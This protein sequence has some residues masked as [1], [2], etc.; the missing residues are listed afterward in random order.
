MDYTPQTPQKKRK[1]VTI[2]I[3]A[4][5]AALLTLA[6]MIAGIFALVFSLL[7][8][9]KES[10]EYKLAYEYLVSS[11]AFEELGAEPD[12]IRFNS[13]SGKNINGDRTVELGFRVEGHSFLVVCHLQ[14]GKWIVCRECTT[15]E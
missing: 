14:D 5:V 1:T 11:Q 6:L 12:E 13:Y 9:Q 3:V 4:C 10:A 8:N 7:D 2:I 15:F